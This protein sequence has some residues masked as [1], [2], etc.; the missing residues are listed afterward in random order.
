MPSSIN[1]Y[2]GTQTSPKPKAADT[3]TADAEDP[4]VDDGTDEDVLDDTSEIDKE[5]ESIAEVLEVSVAQKNQ[6]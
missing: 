4:I 5:K 3:T 2:S 1:A 6:P